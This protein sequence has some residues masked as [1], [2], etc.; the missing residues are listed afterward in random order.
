[1]KKQILL[2]GNSRTSADVF[3]FSGVSIHDDFFCFSIGNKK[4]A[5]LSPLEVGRA[6][7]TSK[8]D[9]IFD[10][11]EVVAQMPKKSAKSYFDAV[12]WLLKKH[13]IRSIVVPTYF[14]VGMFD[15]FLQKGF[16]VEYCDGDFFLERQLK[17]DFEIT[18]IQKAND[19]A[20]AC[21][22][23]VEEILRLSDIRKGF[24]YYKNDILT[25]EYLRTEIEKL[26][27]SMGADALDTIAASGNQAC[28]PHEVG[29][30]PIKA[31]NLIVF[32]IFPRL[33]SSGYYG[34]MTR[35]FLKGEPTKKQHALVDA[36]LEAQSL[37]L[38]KIRAGVDGSDVHASVVR[39]FDDRN[40]QTKVMR[41]HWGGFFHSTGHGL[42]LDVHEGPSLGKNKNI[43]QCGNVI[44]VEPGLY[45]RG[46][47]GCRIEDNVV[48]N[49]SGARMLSKFHYN[50]IID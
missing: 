3:Y 44:T 41:G 35:T 50:W 5:L 30:G 14:P 17:T 21:F 7:R 27:I 24:L 4:C 45:Y 33:R 48:V 40:F 37:A 13:K 15:N 34:D 10:Y 20:S 19:V 22:Y 11:S 39:F 2:Y 18:E 32:D 12:V 6:R 47:G 1:M 31:N 29:H 36:V 38:S 16:D 49:S 25:S 23:L 42:G 9:K 26:A 43:L 46:I 8:L 28:D